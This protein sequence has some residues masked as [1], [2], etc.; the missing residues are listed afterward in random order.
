MGFFISSLGFAGAAGA[1]TF[2][3]TGN[4][5]AGIAVFLGLVSINVSLLGIRSALGK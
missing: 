1:L 2:G 3:A 5:R 4:I